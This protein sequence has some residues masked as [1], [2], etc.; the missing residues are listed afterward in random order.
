MSSRRAFIHRASALGL[1]LLA[2]HQRALAV[3]LA[4]L[5]N[6]DAASGV[7]AALARGAE[8]AVDLLGRTDG[9]LGNPQ[10]RIGLPGQLEDAAKL[11]R[12]FGQGQRIDELVT[13]I[14]RAAETAVPM[15][16]DLLVGAVQSMSVQD[17]K[18]ILTGGDTAVTQFFAGKTRAPL[19]ERFL[20]VVT[21]ATDKVGL[22]QQYN[23]FAGKAAGFGL[24]K[25]EDANLQ[26]Y[27]T[28]K[29][30]DGLY[31]MIGEEERKIRNDP[32]GTGSAL[33]QKVF[34]AR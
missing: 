1:L 28:G 31:F 24:L 34:G 22:A 16:K 14:N 7:K 20:P 32:V 30:L 4:Q 5:S 2:A 11:M 17:A 23:A 21:Q 15:G 33:L 26:Q 19:G 6:A 25:A 8:V 29:T 9:F 3:S 12:R 27:V 13:T 18:N 10:V